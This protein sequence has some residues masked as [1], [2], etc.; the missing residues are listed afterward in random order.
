MTYKALGQRDLRDARIL[1][2]HGGSPSAAGRLIQ[3]A[4]EKH[5]K[6]AIENSGDHGLLPLLQ[7]HNTI[8]PWRK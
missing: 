5:L 3:Q 8:R 4:I 7:I 1:L 2:D 6:Q